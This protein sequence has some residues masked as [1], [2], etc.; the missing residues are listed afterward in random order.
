MLLPMDEMVW[1]ESEQEAADCRGNAPDSQLPKA[2]EGRQRRQGE[3]QEE[4][5][6]HRY[7]KVRGH[8][9]EQ[10]QELLVELVRA[11]PVIGGRRPRGSHHGKGACI[12]HPLDSRAD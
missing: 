11:G 5:Q 2:P 3:A 1:Q 8:Q 6:V 7:R 9:G 10:L 4:K 12:P